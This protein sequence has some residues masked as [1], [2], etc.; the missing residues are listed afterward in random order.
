MAELNQNYKTARQ[1]YLERLSELGLPENPQDSN[2]YD[3]N[4]WREFH[5]WLKSINDNSDYCPNPNELGFLEEIQCTI[6]LKEYGVKADPN[7]ERDWVIQVLEQRIDIRD[8]VLMPDDYCTID[9]RIPNDIVSGDEAE[10]SFREIHPDRHKSWN[11]PLL[12]IN[13]Y[14][15]YINVPSNELEP[16][17]VEMPTEADIDRERILSGLPPLNNASDQLKSDKMLGEDFLKNNHLPIDTYGKPAKS[18]INEFSQAYKVNP[19]V[20]AAIILLIVGS[21]AN[22]KI[23]LRA[24]NY[25]NRPCF[26]LA[27]VERSG[28]NKSEPMSRLMKPLAAIN[29]DLCR[30]FN[31]AYADFAASGSK[32]TPPARQKIIIS[33]STPEIRYQLMVSNGLVLVRDELNGFFK[34]IGRYSSSGEVENLLSTWSGQGFPVDRVNA[35]SFEVETPFLSIIGGIQPRVMAEA[36]GA[37]GFAES[38]FIPRWLFVVPTDSR[39]P[40]SVSEKL[41]DKDLENEW[42]S[43]TLSLWRMERREFRLSTEAKQAYQGYMKRTS[44]I[45]NAPDCDDAIRANYAKLRIY[46]LRFAL[47]IHLLKFG[48]KAVDGIDRK[49]M[50]SAIRTCDVFAYWNRQSLSLISGTDAKKSISNAELLRLLCERYNVTNQS[51]LARLIS[52]SQQYVSKVLGTMNDG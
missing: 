24:W 37:K 50:D 32:G 31:K 17:A 41:I 52:R 10:R 46:C 14:Y 22:R 19:D 30:E 43:L 9:N 25:I 3:W 20:I 8:S 23:T 27:I 4:L 40:D 13:N 51:E 18:L 49:T 48:A 36:F 2:K 42:Y 12:P 35:A 5:N 45:M 38:G 39:V 21:A 47:V 33:D 7:S 29:K 28:S 11:L 44:D 15:D 1:L 26:W 6:I 16:I 34:D